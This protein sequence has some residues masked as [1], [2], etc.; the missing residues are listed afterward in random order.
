MA[1]SASARFFASRG[2]VRSI[3]STVDAKE[4]DRAGTAFLLFLSSLSLARRRTFQIARRSRSRGAARKR[5]VRA[6][7]AGLISYM[8][9][10]TVGKKVWRP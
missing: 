7:S 9:P 2:G 8:H 5:L 10:L 3:G 4:L 1:T 6:G